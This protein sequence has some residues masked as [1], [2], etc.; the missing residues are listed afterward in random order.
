MGHYRARKCRNVQTWSACIWSVQS[1]WETQLPLL[2]DSFLQYKHSRGG[3]NQVFSTPTPETFTLLLID[4]YGMCLWLAWM[5]SCCWPGYWWCMYR[6]LRGPPVSAAPWVYVPQHES[7]VTRVPQF[8]T[9]LCFICG[10]IAHS[11][12]LSSV[13][14]LPTSSQHPSMGSDPVWLPQCKF[15]LTHVLH[16][17]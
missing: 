5:L 9:N 6:L 4:V 2:I 13:A 12:T 1:K 7:F 8:C 14:C 15:I 17:I 16:L 11:G 10:L 3:E